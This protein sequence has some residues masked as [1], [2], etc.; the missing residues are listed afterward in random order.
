MANARFIENQPI[1]QQIV[2]FGGVEIDGFDEEGAAITSVPLREAGV[3][4]EGSGGYICGGSPASD[5]D[6]LTV[7]VLRG[8]NGFRRLRRAAIDTTVGR[9]SVRPRNLP[10]GALNYDFYS[11]A[12]VTT[13]NG[14]GPNYDQGDKFATFTIY[15]WGYQDRNVNII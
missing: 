8:S 3:P 10:Q 5:T 2:L 7:R 15:A 4:V 12:Q 1:A 9:F 6:V 14:R 11:C 13:S